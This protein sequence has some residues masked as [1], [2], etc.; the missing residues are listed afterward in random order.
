[1]DIILPFL[2]LPLAIENEDAPIGRSFEENLR[3]IE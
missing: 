1:V 3:V 2:E